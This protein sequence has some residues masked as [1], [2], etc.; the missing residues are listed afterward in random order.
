MIDENAIATDSAKKEKP[1]IFD[2]FNA[3]LSYYLRNIVKLTWSIAKFFILMSGIFS[4]ASPFILFGMILIDPDGA[5]KTVK[6]LAEI[7]ETLISSIK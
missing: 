4:L 7:L 2:K 3:K 5:V 6:A 1:R